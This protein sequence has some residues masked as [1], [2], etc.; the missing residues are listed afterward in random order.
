[1][2]N[3]FMYFMV[4]T[5]SVKANTITN[6]YKRHLA[7]K[8]C[9]LGQIKPIKTNTLNESDQKCDHNLRLCNIIV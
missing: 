3:V 7:G 1:M 9:L 8:L 6:Y 5:Y 2:F 4:I